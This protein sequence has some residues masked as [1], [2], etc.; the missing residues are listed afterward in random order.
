MRGAINQWN[1]WYEAKGAVG[2]RSRKPPGATPKLS[3]NQRQELI[4]LI[5]AGPI[6]AGYQT[7][8]WTGPMIGNFIKRRFAIEYHNHHIPRLLHA[9]GFS[10]QR[11]RRKLARADC[12]KQQ[13]WLENVLPGIKKKRQPV[14][15]WFYSGMR[16][17]SGS[18][19]HSTKPGHELGVSQE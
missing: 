9:L 13:D 1:R 5:E 4:T 16:P 6:A 11:P 2:L 10:V 17:V 8:I 7:G 14:V 12:E 19:A 3:E 15:E 18:M